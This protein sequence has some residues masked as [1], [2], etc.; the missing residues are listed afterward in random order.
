MRPLILFLFLFLSWGQAQ[1]DL[2]CWLGN[3][4]IDLGSASFTGG[5]I[6]SFLCSGLVLGGL[7]SSYLPPDSVWM[8]V[9]GL[10]IVCNLGTLVCIH[11][12]CSPGPFFPLLRFPFS[13]LFLF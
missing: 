8:N 1:C 11:C 12:S 13:F 2:S 6:E 4:T 10:K 3:L 7:S 5:Q 9:T